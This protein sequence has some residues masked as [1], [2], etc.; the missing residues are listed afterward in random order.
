MTHLLVL[1]LDNV[2]QCPAVLD[3]WQKAGVRG[4]T[5]MESTGLGRVRS[6]IRDDLP[7]VPSLRDL[8]SSQELHHRTLFTVVDDEEILRRLIDA[9]KEIVGD[10]SRPNTGLLFV[11]PVSFVLGLRKQHGAEEASPC[12]SS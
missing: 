6:V 1:V 4:V 11:V 3:A 7:L 8:L 5:I 12:P 10:F 9:T 2:E